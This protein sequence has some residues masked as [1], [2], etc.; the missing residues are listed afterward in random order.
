MT[1]LFRVFLFFVIVSLW[2]PKFSG[3]PK[4]IGQ[5]RFLEFLI[6]LN[7]IPSFTPDNSYNRFIQQCRHY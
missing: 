1:G 2:Q 5:I 6:T 7:G 4:K 3:F